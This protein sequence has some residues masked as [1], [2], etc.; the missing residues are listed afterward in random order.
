VKDR[1]RE[2][3]T[4]KER[5]SARAHTHTHTQAHLSREPLS[6]ARAYKKN[7]DEKNYY[8]LGRYPCPLHMLTRNACVYVC[9]F[10]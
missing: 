3:D 10:I 1:D 8:F 2:R 5:E 9:V 4:Q 7:V 6:F